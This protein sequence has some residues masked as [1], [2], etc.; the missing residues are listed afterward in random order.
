MYVDT[1]FSAIF[2]LL[3]SSTSVFGYIVVGAFVNESF[4]MVVA[5][6]ERQGTKGGVTF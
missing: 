2:Y 5:V 3:L 1:Q 6:G 4:I